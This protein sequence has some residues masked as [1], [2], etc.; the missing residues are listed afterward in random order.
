MS[1][2]P[3]TVRSPAITNSTTATM[4]AASR[5]GAPEQP[6]T[7]VRALGLPT[8]FG[9][10]KPDLV[11]DQARDL[12]G[13]RGT[14]CPAEASSGEVARFIGPP[15]RRGTPCAASRSCLGD[16]RPAPVPVIE[17]GS[18]LPT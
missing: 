9:L 17:P 4:L 7:H 8:N 15:R 18:P 5:A 10:G 12:L 3:T 16:V 13:E 1:L 11:A 6:R 14:S 2:L